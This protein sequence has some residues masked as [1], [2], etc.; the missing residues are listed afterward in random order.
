MENLCLICSGIFLWSNNQSHD[1]KYY[2]INSYKYLQ[3]L[4]DLLSAFFN[5]IKG[6]SH[7]YKLWGDLRP[8]SQSLDQKI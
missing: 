4:A 7:A 5:F 8:C 6:V 2:Y 1:Y 3:Y